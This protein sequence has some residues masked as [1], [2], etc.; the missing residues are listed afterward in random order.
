M[1]IKRSK[2]YIILIISLCLLVSLGIYKTGILK[3]TSTSNPITL[4]VSLYKYI[5]QY[6]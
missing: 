4:N 6:L 5:P 3:K 2:L 1:K